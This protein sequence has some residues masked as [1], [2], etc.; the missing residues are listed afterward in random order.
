MEGASDQENP[1]DKTKKI[2]SLIN[3]IEK[4]NLSLNQV[5]E[6]IYKSNARIAILE[7]ENAKLKDKIENPTWGLSKQNATTE[8]RYRRPKHYKIVEHLVNY[9]FNNELLEDK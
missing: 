5:S 8:D 6:H 7:S 9:F 2:K 3:E 4:G 1:K